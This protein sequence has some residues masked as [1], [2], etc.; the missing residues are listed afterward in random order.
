MISPLAAIF[1]YPIVAI[2]L[3]RAMPRRAALIWTF[4]L[5]YLFLPTRTSYNLPLL[6]PI[7]KSTM[8]ALAALIFAPLIGR[9]EADTP[10]AAVQPG[11]LPR[12]PWA[13]ALIAL[14]LIGGFMTAL[15]NGDRLFFGP[16]VLPALRLYDGFSAALGT[17][18]LFLPM[19]LARKYLASEDSHKLLLKI[20]AIAGVIYSLP[21]IFELVMSPQLNRIV[22]GFFPHSWQ[23]HVRGTG[24]RP[25]V[26]LVHGLWLGIFMCCALLGALAYTRVAAPGRRFTWLV[27]GAWLFV[28]LYLCKSLG[29]FAIALVFVPVVMFLK[30]RM[31]LLLV[32]VVAGGILIYPALRGADLVP[33][34][35]IADMAAQIDEGRAKSLRFRLRNED[36]LLARAQERPYFGWGV[37]DRARVFDDSGRDTSTTDGYWVIQIGQKGW[38]GYLGH[39]GLLCGSVMLLALRRKTYG[40]ALAT[41]GLC[42]VLTANLIDLVPNAGITSVTWLITG[43]LIGRLERKGAEEDAPAAPA[44]PDTGLRYSRFDHGATRPAVSTTRFHGPATLREI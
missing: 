38:A 28:I 43:A 9:P 11:W 22:Y 24:Y 23:Q 30:V 5:G 44:A 3:F 15:T 8:P 10:G 32:A 2:V 40:I 21:I 6:P 19:L 34:D 18:M 7:D 37:W 14:T 12:N 27:V 13:L 39:F 1:I 36:A 41:S 29:A 33:V 35:R 31:Q 4:V 17:I 26:F 20:L 42:I 16:T 25:L